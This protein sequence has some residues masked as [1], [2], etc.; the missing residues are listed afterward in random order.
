MANK[1]LV[2]D[3]EKTIRVL[4]RKILEN[5]QYE[6]IESTNG[7]EAV[8][9][10]KKENPDVILLDMKMPVMD[11]IETCRRLRADEKT[12]NIPI[13]VIT[14]LGETKMEAI[15][16]GVDDFINKPFDTEEVI[17]RVKSMLKIKNLTDGLQRISAY[18]DGIAKQKK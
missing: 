3:D 8:E 14:A 16:A 5:E 12:K 13:L 9:S 15:K 18:G 6:V 4:I 7:Y 1:I 11:G 2:V 10:A 17:I